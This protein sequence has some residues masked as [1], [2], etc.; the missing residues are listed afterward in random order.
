MMRIGGWYSQNADAQGCQDYFML[1]M[2]SP[3]EI[4]ASPWASRIL[5][6]P[7]MIA[8]VP[9]RMKVATLSDETSIS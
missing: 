5:H 3:R 6:L 8:G 2:K 1:R 9:G 4:L 7:S